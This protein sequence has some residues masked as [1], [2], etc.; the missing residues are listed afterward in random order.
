MAAG[1][2]FLVAEEADRHEDYV[3]RLLAAED[4]VL[5]DVFSIG[6]PNA[7]HRVLRNA[8][9]E[10]GQRTAG[11][12]ADRQRGGD[13]DQMAL[14]AGSGVAALTRVEPAAVIFDRLTL[15]R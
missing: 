4:A 3:E 9:L 10:A 1:T 8:A 11:R 5:T 14:Y 2:S 7:P 6:W 12:D 15:R 13:A